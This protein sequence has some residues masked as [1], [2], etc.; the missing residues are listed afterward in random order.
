[1]RTRRRLY[2]LVTLV[3]ATLLAPPAH[4][5]FTMLNV[6]KFA[7]LVNTGDPTRNGGHFVVRRDRALQPIL[8]PGCPAA[9]VV[10]I[11]AY[12]QSTYRDA[13]LAQ[14]TLECG[15]WTLRGTTW[16]YSDPTGTIRSIRYG[17]SGLRIDVQ[18]PGYTPIGGPVGFIQVQLTIGAQTLRARFHNFETNDG[19]EVIARKPS[20]PA[21]RGEAGFWDVLT[22]DDAT[23]AH[24]QE[25]IGF[26]ERAAAGNAR[27]GRSRFLLGMMHLYRFGQQV[28]GFE[29]VPEAI[30]AELR[31]G[32]AWFAES[33]PLLW[34]G[35]T[36]TGD[37][38]VIGF[39]G[40]G[41][42]TQ[43]VVDNDPV[44]RT[45]ALADLRQAVTVNAF[46]NVFDLI[47]VLQ[48]TLPNDP[49]FLSA[50]TTVISYL[51]DPATL[52]CVGTQPELCS[53]A[54]MAP[55]NISGSLTLFGDLYIKGGDLAKATTWY[56]LAA[57]LQNPA[58]PWPFKSVIDD[59]VAHAGARLALYQDADPSNDPPLIG[60]GA[61][62]CAVCHARH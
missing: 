14:V 17:R 62:A 33:L 7:R 39:V 43:S 59:R 51:E 1:M 53:N 8:S 2:T 45:E 60:A 47:P 34:N 9:S 42:F 20:P 40:A 36:L 32:N 11:E 54:G 38:R 13:V 28:T 57:A 44:L 3:V 15:K 29:N 56:N 41:K 49:L 18:G 4:A 6:G 21:A 55:N 31:S 24:Q 23:E 26:L 10:E 46:F 5:A 61:E 25:T 12:L 52:A 48:A 37:S 19:T 35:A 16:R 50:F 22:A 27:D 30:K 58:N